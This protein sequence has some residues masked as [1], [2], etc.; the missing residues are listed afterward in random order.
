[1][2]ATFVGGGLGMGWMGMCADVVV[3]ITDV[4]A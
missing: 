4:M 3:G 2:F 1:M